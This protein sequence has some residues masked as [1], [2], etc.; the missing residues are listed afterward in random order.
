MKQ[1]QFQ[2]RHEA[3]WAEIEEF[4]NC[5]G[6]RNKTLPFTAADF[7]RRYRRLCQQLA[8]ARTRGYSNALSEHLHDLVHRAHQS[9]YSGRRGSWRS[10]AQFVLVDYPVL[11]RREWRC[12]LAAALL[13]MGPLLLLIPLIGAAPEVAF[14]ILPPSQVQQVE[15]MYDPDLRD[16][17][18]RERETETDVYMFG[19]YVRNNTSIGFQT[20]VGGALF[21]LGT[22]FFLVYN[23]LYI[24]AVAGHLTALGYTET[25]WGFVAGHS[26]F[27]LTAI[28]LSG[29][30]GLKVGFALLAPGGRT[31]RLAFRES[32]AIAIRLM[33]GA[34]LLFLAAAFVEA[35]WSSI[36][37]IPVMV[38]YSVGAVAWLI[39]V[40]YIM[41][42]GRNRAT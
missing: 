10:V 29:A 11:V 40:A 8:I 24:G 38:K 3:E 17:I 18:G 42:P 41:L 15:M 4:L 31:R 28:M 26:A 39:T 36:A 25:F 5:A 7:P 22:V 33:Y 27:E 14:T 1:S 19:F 37:S 30:A 34:A 9:F 21:G 2:E 6:K 12:L 32:M 23:G 16:R 35:F 13:F 20:F